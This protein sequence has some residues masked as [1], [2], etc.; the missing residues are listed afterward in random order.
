MANN[1]NF[2]VKNGLDVT[3]NITVGGTVDGRDL[4]AD[5]NKLDGV[6]TGAEANPSAS[7]MLT[8][9]KTVDGS[10]SG[11]D[12]DTV[13]GVQAS[14]FVRG[15]GTN[16]SAITIRADNTDFVIQDQAD[17]VTNFIWRDH[18][19][20][21]LYLG[22]ANAVITARSTI[23]ANSN[24]ITN[25]SKITFGTGNVQA[26]TTSDTSTGARLILY[27]SSGGN[28]YAIGIES[29]SMWFNSYQNY[30]WY[31]GG[32]KYGTL[33]SDYFLHTSD[34]RSPIFYDSANTSYYVD[35]A[36]TSNLSGLNVASNT[37]NG[38]Q[39]RPT[40]SA[41]VGGAGWYRVASNTSSSGRGDF[42]VHVFTTGGSY[43]PRSL[44]IKGRFDWGTI[45]LLY[46]VDNPQG[47]YWNAVR[48]TKD[49]SA[50]HV[51]VYFTSA[52]S[53]NQLTIWTESIGHDTFYPN[54]G[55]LAAGGG[56][57]QDSMSIV[58]RT[59]F[60]GTTYNTADFRAPIFY[61]SDDTA[62]Y[63]NPA[64]TSLL[65]ALEFGDSAGPTLS[66]ERDQNLKLQGGS[67]GDVGITGYG[68]DG[69]WDF[70]LYGSGG[71]QGFLR[72]NWG[73]WSAY[74]DTSGNWTGTSSVRA[75]IFYDSNDTNYYVDPAS[76][77][78]IYDLNVIAK[79][80]DFG[81]S[82]NWDAVG[83]GNQ[84]NVH[85]QG[86]NQFWV[87]AGNGTWF[88]GTANTKSQ[89]S[90]LAADASVAHDLLL[91]TMPSTNT[92]DRGVTFG[93]DSNGAGT[94]G[95]RLGKWHSGDA[96]D[97]SKLVVDGGLFVKGGYT[98]EYDYYANDYSAYYSG[99]GGVAY[100]GGDTGWDDP[101]G[102]FSTAIQI[103]SGNAGTNTRNPQLQFHQYGYGG[104][105]F[106]YDGPNDRM[107]LESTASDRMDWFRVKTDH[108][109]IEIGPANT[110][111]AHI[112]TDRSAFYFDK[113][114]YVLGGSHMNQNDIRSAIFYDNDNTAYYVNPNSDSKLYNIDSANFMCVGGGTNQATNNPYNSVSSTRLMFG[115]RD[116]NAQ[117]A[118]YIGTNIENYGGS[119]TKL[120][121][122][123]HTGIRMGARPNYGGVRIFSDETLS[124]SIFSVGETDANVRVA[125]ILYAGSFYDINNTGYYVDPNN[126]G[127]SV[128]VAG[129]VTAYYS[130][131]RLKDIE[132]NIDNPLEKVSKL[133]G[134]YY[135]ANKT[136]QKFGYKDDRQVGVSAQ[137]VE[138]V[139]PEIVSDA[140][141]GHGYKTVDYSKLVP[142]LIEAIK[143]QQKQIDDLKLQIKN[144]GE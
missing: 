2:K 54:S 30:Y 135:K 77:S 18:N 1:H 61:D 26:P 124:T 55:T 143:D 57:V 118:Y 44:F 25:G 52:I 7:E 119:Y 91:T 126:T 78:N 127:T 29:N 3:G 74:A 80:S 75:P 93:V 122:R 117:G 101:S 15:D 34:I 110:S 17:S 41:T 56:T 133:N 42:N 48:I 38:R 138:A 123:W 51:E 98:D 81:Q 79:R 72:S 134:F 103:Q 66:Q 62:F 43:T 13:D 19:V 87:G 140:A 108:G 37:I 82:S 49:G 35:P 23:D 22:T 69:N 120:D 9:I 86:H 11:L 50:A 141:I 71:Q 94:A 12:A 53:G 6:S 4:V 97:S 45:G 109:Y 70:Q 92:Y 73:S 39:F 104:V 137:E 5:G 64:S 47:G 60:I 83:F 100:W 24:E 63:V 33:N 144:I 32:T 112:Y 85:F 107:Y 115:A 27:P 114:I 102:T 8:S 111:W 113:S 136:A 20:N 21:K 65:N 40:A 106:R 88:T 128:R 131:E 142:L 14:G 90:G 96:A 10:G 59:N 99:R 125:N 105:Q 84:T 121:F 139:M 89:A 16:Q 67:G 31:V 129:N 76:T 28:N 130:D 68:G 116:S 95:W 46:Q 58:G 36:S 132:S